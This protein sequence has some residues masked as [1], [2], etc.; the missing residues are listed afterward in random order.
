M[1]QFNDLFK[2]KL[3]G[4]QFQEK[5]KYWT[6]LEKRLD[7]AEREKGFFLRFKKW[8]LPTLLV[9]FAGLAAYLY[10]HRAKQTSIAQVE[11]TEDTNQAMLN[12][13]IM[14]TTEKQVVDASS[15]ARDNQNLSA[16]K[17]SPEANTTMSETQII[18]TAKVYKAQNAAS[19]KDDKVMTAQGNEV[20]Y[21]ANN[22]AFNASNVNQHS[23]HENLPSAY[24]PELSG[25]NEKQNES[26][27]APIVA[28]INGVESTGAIINNS[29]PINSMGMLFNTLAIKGLSPIPFFEASVVT[30]APVA[31]MPK[32]RKSNYELNLTVYGGAMLSMKNMWLQ[33]VGLENYL[34]RRKVE[35]QAA[36]TPN[37]GIDIELGRG[38][39]TLTSGVNFH[40]QSDTRNYSDRF[41]RQVPY[42][43]IV[44]NI[45]QNSA[46]IYDSTVFSTY[47]YSN[48]INSMDSTITYYDQSSGVFL[49]T[50]IPVN[51][52]QS[53]ITDTNFYYQIDSMLIQTI[54]T[55]TTAYQLS[56]LQTVNDANQPHLKGRNTFTY[57]EV[58]LLL[59]YERG[60]G[61]FRCSIKG[62]VGVGFLTRQQSYYLATDESEIIPISSEVYQK[63]IYS[64]VVRLGLHYSI[65]PQLGIDL[66]PFSRMNFNRMT[67]D[68][69][70]AQQRYQNL[71]L[72]IGLRLKL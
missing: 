58:P 21:V 34:N 45:N 37:I 8:F 18:P 11:H 27:V 29:K 63:V 57:V 24:N 14:S 12:D 41:K 13:T 25:S 47:Q 59:G 46:W 70:S 4:Q 62:G 39:W 9:G 15:N 54:D 38:H 36:V 51:N 71:G 42:D 44:F 26:Q 2:K 22:K 28:P 50:T 33:N 10:T 3:S 56:R 48:V 1:T 30:P 66:V 5:D 23:E 72:Q 61:K 64:G 68:K 55:T 19:T 49:T 16:G 32:Q 31:A 17:A 43:S 40:Q 20:S 7:R 67:N 35:E 52:I 6:Q 53:I 69:A 65:T 60:F